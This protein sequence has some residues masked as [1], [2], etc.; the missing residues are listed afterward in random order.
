MNQNFD[1]QENLVKQE[2]SN[3]NKSKWGE[4]HGKWRLH[5]RNLGAPE[6][7]EPD[8]SMPQTQVCAFQVKPAQC[9]LERAGERAQW[10]QCLLQKLQDLM[11]VLTIRAQNQAQRCACDPA[12]EDVVVRRSLEL[13][14]QPG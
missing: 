12:L 14:D 1:K 8:I 3:E 5:L 6:H 4:K 11:G 13:A 2:Q 9:E 7:Q 10:Q